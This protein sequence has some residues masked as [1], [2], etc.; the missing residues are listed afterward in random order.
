MLRREQAA[1]VPAEPPILLNVFRRLQY[2]IVINQLP[3]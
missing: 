3:R 1:R 2:V